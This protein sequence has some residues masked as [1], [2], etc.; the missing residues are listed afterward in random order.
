MKRRKGNSLI[1]VICVFVIVFTLGSIISSKVMHNTLWTQQQRE[2]TVAYYVMMGGIELGTN[3]ALTPGVDADG[4][5]VPSIIEKY[6]DNHKK[7]AIKD[8]FTYDN[9]DKVEIEIK[10]TDVNG[11]A[12]PNGVS[13]AGIWVQIKATGYSYNKGGKETIYVGAIRLNAVEP[14]RI[15]RDIRLPYE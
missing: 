13:M 9:G 6:R 5:D 12:L 15:N 4:K 14:S 1:L 2:R 3:A 8:T 10:A 7:A 11:D